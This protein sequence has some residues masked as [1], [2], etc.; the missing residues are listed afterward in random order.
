MLNTIFARRSIRKFASE[1]VSEDIVRDLLRAAMAAP[2]A[3]NEQPWHFVVLTDRALLDQVPSV[4]PY[5]KMVREA[6]AAVLVCGD[7]NLAKHGEMWVQDCA[8]ATQNLL[9]AA[10]AKGLGS[11][12]LGVYP[13]GDRV[14]GLRRLCNLPSHIMPFA[15][16]PIGHPAEHKPPHGEY[17][18]TRVHRDTW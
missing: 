15:L 11:V 13:R 2:S 3:G 12:W 18:D 7:L 5:S 4:H 8:A 10:Q 14:A 9:L 16:L 1:P 6:P 17:D